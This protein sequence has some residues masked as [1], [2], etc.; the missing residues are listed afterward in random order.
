[1]EQSGYLLSRRATLLAF[2]GVML[3]MLVAALNQTIISTALPVI[4][5]DLGGFDHYSWVFT[6]YMLGSTVTVP[7]FGRLSDVYGR[8][9][10]F[11][12]GIVLFMAGS[13]VAGTS[14]SM[15]QLVAGRAVQGLGAGALIPLAMA[16][17]GDLVP[18]SERGKWQ[19]LVGV[20]FGVSSV[21]GPTL[22]GWIV[23]N[24][25]WRWV[26]FVSMPVGLVALGVV[27]ATLKLPRHPEAAQTV[28][29]LGAS[30]L[31]AGLS[32]ALLATLWGGQQYPWG[33]TEI[34]G[35]YA[36]AAVFLALFALQE[37]RARDPILPLSL[38]RSRTIAGASF[39][40]FAV[41][42]AMF[43][44]IMF[45]PL[46]VQG[47]LGISATDSGVTLTP[48]MLAMIVT[49]V[50][51]GQVISRTGRYRWALL[52]GPVVMAAGF[53]LLLRL[54]TG[55]TGGQVALAMIVLGLGL[56]LLMQNLVLVVQNAVPSRLLGVATGSTQLFRQLGAAI[57]VSVMGALLNHRLA[58]EL[59]ARAGEHGVGSGAVLAPG[60]G[61][62][63]LVRAR[64][65][66]ERDPLDLLDRPGADGAGAGG[67][68]LRPRAAAAPSGARGRRPPG[69]RGG[70][71]ARAAR[72]GGA[73]RPRQAPT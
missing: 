52:A 48:L 5:D 40:G 46:F 1:M 66:R 60:G 44:A 59:G 55:A 29:Y 12:L 25:D 26:F 16:V 22:G 17:I 62:E 67:A 45:V 28:D 11:M 23:D 37:R 69:P 38:F 51:S 2:G 20:V 7:I 30:L 63:P 53:G 34:V 54:S 19:G 56:G 6:A 47:A 41:G 18:P 27:W 71:L 68:A 24:A 42:V 70:S 36:A 58:A 65:A 32:S 73:R 50:G 35:L 13:A 8:R 33:S 31:T 39:A 9:P 3:G 10:L 72:G 61:Q 49:S 14:G 4:V 15:T 64:G 43:G 57:G 21:F